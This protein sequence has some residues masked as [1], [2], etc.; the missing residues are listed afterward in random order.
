[1]KIK[2]L[3]A[4][5]NKVGIS[6]LKAF[7]QH[8]METLASAIRQE[9]KQIGKEKLKQTTYSRLFLPHQY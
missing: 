9:K 8:S 1:L 7:I 4:Q 2:I 3:S 5:S 6:I